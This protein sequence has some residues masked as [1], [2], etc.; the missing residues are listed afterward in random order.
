MTAGPV[1]GERSESVQTIGHAVPADLLA[2]TPSC[3]RGRP[4]RIRNTT[5]ATLTLAHATEAAARLVRILHQRQRPPIPRAHHGELHS[6]RIDIERRTI[7]THDA[8]QPSQ[9]TSNRTTGFP[10]GDLQTERRTK[11]WCP[12]PAPGVSEPRHALPVAQA[13]VRRSRSSLV[14]ALQIGSAR[15]PA[16]VAGRDLGPYGRPFGWFLGHPQK[17]TPL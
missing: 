2:R 4:L 10:T 7:A 14:A 6:C 9:P 15:I 1:I 3:L 12:H 8:T 16:R 11:D 13:A 5:T 17:T